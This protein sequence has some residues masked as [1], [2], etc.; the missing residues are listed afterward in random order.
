MK[1]KMFCFMTTVGLFLLLSSN[2]LAA[3]ST[4]VCVGQIEK[5]Y[6]TGGKLYI[7]T[8]G[9]ERNLNCSAVADVYVTLPT[10]NTD[11]KNYYAM[12]L[13]SMTMN[14]TIGLRIAEGSNGCELAYAYIE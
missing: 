9:D 1:R 2:V 3:C 10:S 5:L 7:G 13:T 11:F 8:D 12:M 14:N 4:K 6:I